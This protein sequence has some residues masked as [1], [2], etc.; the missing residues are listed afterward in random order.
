MRVIAGRL[1]RGRG[2]MTSTCACVLLGS[3]FS[4]NCSRSA[5]NSDGGSSGDG[6]TSGR[7]ISRW[8]RIVTA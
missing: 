8:Y 6:A 2:A 1:S 4:P 3:S 7:G 5:V